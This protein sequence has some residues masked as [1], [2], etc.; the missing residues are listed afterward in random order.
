M[1]KIRFPRQI[2]NEFHQEVSQGTKSSNG[3]KE[4]LTWKLDHQLNQFAKSAK[5]SEEKEASE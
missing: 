2:I 5:S 3:W 1:G 4:D